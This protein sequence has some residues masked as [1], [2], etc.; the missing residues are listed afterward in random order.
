MDPREGAVEL[1]PLDQIMPRLYSRIILPFS[2][3]AEKLDDA[4]LHLRESLARTVQEI[5][6]L[7]WDVA[8][9]PQGR[10]QLELNPR[11]PV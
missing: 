7:A 6:F 3:E 9:S 5:P 11:S 1:S 4:A 2:L 10:G 8:A